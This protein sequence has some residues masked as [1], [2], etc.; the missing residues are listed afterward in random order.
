MAL[1]ATPGPCGALD[2]LFL[3]IETKLAAKPATKVCCCGE[4]LRKGLMIVTGVLTVLFIADSIGG[5]R[6]E[7]LGVMSS[8]WPISLAELIFGLV[9]AYGCYGLYNRQPEGARLLARTNLLLAVFMVLLL[10]TIPLWVPVVCQ[11]AEDLALDND[12]ENCASATAATCGKIAAQT[13]LTTFAPPDTPACLSGQ[14]ITWTLAGADTACPTGSGNVCGI[15][16]HTGTSCDDASAVGG[17]LFADDLMDADPWTAV[18]YSADG[19][20]AS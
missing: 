10:V 19:A 11:G 3:P 17:H 14:G 15:H 6:L 12:R 7:G 5:L 16:I 20:G 9:S 13:D 2:A 4:D 18:R 8:L 1:Q